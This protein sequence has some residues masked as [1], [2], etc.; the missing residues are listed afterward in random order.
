MPKT[1]IAGAE[2]QRHDRLVEGQP[3]A[4]AGYQL[5]PVARL[6]GWHWLHPNGRA[7]FGFV[8]LSPTEVVVQPP[9]GEEQHLALPIPTKNALFG[10]L[11]AAAGL[12]V[13][14]TAIMA[15]ARLASRR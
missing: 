4:A 6:S 9:E 14:C 7:G 15:L 12:A 2:V 10:M 11:G 3:V 1:E 5:R 8:H 13:V